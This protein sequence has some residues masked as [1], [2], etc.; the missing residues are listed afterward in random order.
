M[1]IN[2]MD[3]TPEHQGNTCSAPMSFNGLLFTIVFVNFVSTRLVG[4]IHLKSGRYDKSA[5]FPT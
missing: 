4:T 1:E 5:V 2:Q 3:C